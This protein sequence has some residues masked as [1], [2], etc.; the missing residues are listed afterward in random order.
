MQ[1]A[2]Q[3]LLT[4]R[5]AADAHNVLLEV[6]ANKQEEMRALFSQLCSSHTQR[7]PGL[8]FGDLVVNLQRQPH[9]SIA[10]RMHLMHF[11][12][13]S[14]VPA[15]VLH[16]REN[17]FARNDSPTLDQQNVSFAVLA[18][19]IGKTLLELSPPDYA[20]LPGLL[21]ALLLSFPSSRG[22]LER[23]T[24]MTLDK[25]AALWWQD[26]HHMLGGAYSEEGVT[27]LIANQRV[28][29]RFCAEV[30]RRQQIATRRT[31]NVKADRYQRPFTCLSIRLYLLMQSKLGPLTA[32]RSFEIFA[33]VVGRILRMGEEQAT[34]GE[35]T[36]SAD[37]PLQLFVQ[38]LLQSKAFAD[39]N[40]LG[41]VLQ[42][43]FD[44]LA[45]VEHAKLMCANEKRRCFRWCLLHVSTSQQDLLLPRVSQRG[46]AQFREFYPEAVALQ[47]ADTLDFLQTLRLFNNA[48]NRRQSLPLGVPILAHSR[49]R[50]FL[51]H[52]LDPTFVSLFNVPPDLNVTREAILIVPGSRHCAGA[53]AAIFSSPGT[54]TWLETFSVTAAL[55]TENWSKKIPYFPILL[56]AYAC[57]SQGDLRTLGAVLEVVVFQ[58]SIV[59]NIS[60]QERKEV[61]GQAKGQLFAGLCLLGEARL[62]Q[63]PDLCDALLKADVNFGSACAALLTFLGL[64]SV[65]PWSEV[66]RQC[67]DNGIP[68][69]ERVR[70]IAKAASVQQQQ[71]QH[72]ATRGI[73]TG[74]CALLGD[75]GLLN[76]VANYT[77]HCCK[78]LRRRKPWLAVTAGR[79]PQRRLAGRLCSVSI[80]ARVVPLSTPRLC[81][82]NRSSALSAPKHLCMRVALRCTRMR[83]CF[84]EHA[85][86]AASQC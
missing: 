3:A 42:E 12:S 6:F 7:S 72:Q 47:I 71:A 26:P 22:F 61:Q 14:D 43:K 19:S 69:A 56:R 23:R 13:N 80:A 52:S 68:C 40:R 62:R 79:A 82:A 67:L 85:P 15:A 27:F 1:G 11:G 25:L 16:L 83:L 36:P 4:G 20:K 30:G 28:N 35:T 70:V 10:L 58:A 2:M 8:P 60:E 86:E 5:F 31:D 53:C 17:Q 74:L 38:T 34:V 59:A 39:V 21:F 64:I 41:D 73:Y 46:I 18:L 9:F 50:Q 63:L 55:T 57:C 24:C 29:E 32:A 65:E 49:E 44:G 37:L 76:C 78:P 75:E 33:E 45:E 48:T 77:T 81:E 66:L 51:E 84:A 54:K